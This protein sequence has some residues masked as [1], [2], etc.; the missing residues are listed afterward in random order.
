MRSLVARQF[1]PRVI[2]RMQE[3]MQQTTDQ[4]LDTV[5]AKGRMEVIEDL[6]FPM[7]MV[8][9]SRMLGVPEEEAEQFK[10]WS[11]DFNAY[12]GGAAT[13]AQEMQAYESLQALTVYFREL[14]HRRR[15][16]PQDD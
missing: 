1:T 3:Q 4:L 16:D 12:F 9:I 6:A 2:A 13:L 14:L 11:A 10:K 5:A 15:A 8:A 7:P